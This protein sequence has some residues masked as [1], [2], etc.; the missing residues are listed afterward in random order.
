MDAPTDRPSGGLRRPFRLRVFLASAVLLVLLPAAA[1]ADDMIAGNLGGLLVLFG[2]AIVVSVG[3]VVGFT[4][5]TCF[6]E[7]YIMNLF[8]KLGYRRCFWYAVVANLVS[9]GLGLIWYYAGGQ[10]GWKTALRHGEF[11]A[12]A[13]LLA[14][15]FIITIAEETVVVV[16]LLRKQRDFETAFKAVAAM[17]AASYA[18]L[19]VITAL[20]GLV[21]HP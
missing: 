2:V 21:R 8:L 3:A 19:G 1:R 13:L 7:G 9:M 18:L 17:N 16:L 6:L 4:A 5:V 20:L 15:S 12:V 14:R 11:G 10:T